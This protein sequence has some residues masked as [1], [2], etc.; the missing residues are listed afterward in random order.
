M[1]TLPQTTP[2]RLPR[3]AGGTPLAIPSGP[4]AAGPAGGF[5][6]TGADVWRVIRANLWLV[7]L[8][9]VVCGVGGYFF[10]GYLEKNYAIYTAT[11]YIRILPVQ[12]MDPLALGRRGPLRRRPPA[13]RVVR[14]GAPRAPIVM[15]N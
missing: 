6:M 7:I 5:Q 15:A 12:Q 3:P 4:A 8:L 14:P 2:I 9:V 10:N 1:T 13:A 11:G